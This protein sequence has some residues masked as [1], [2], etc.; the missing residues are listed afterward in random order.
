M[1]VQSADA[2]QGRYTDSREPYHKA[3]IEQVTS[4]VDDFAEVKPEETV[5]YHDVH[6]SHDIRRSGRSMTL[7]DLPLEIF[8]AIVEWSLSEPWPSCDLRVFEKAP[9]TDHHE[10]LQYDNISSLF[11]GV[12]KC[13]DVMPKKSIYAAKT[14]LRMSLVCKDFHHIVMS[15]KTVDKV[16]WRKAARSY[17]DLP[18]ELR[19]IQGAKHS[20]SW[21][22]V[23]RAFCNFERP[24][25]SFGH[26]KQCK[27]ALTWAEFC[28][29][30]NCFDMT[31]DR[32]SFLCIQPGPDVFDQVYDRGSQTYTLNLG[33][34]GGNTLVSIDEFG[35]LSASFRVPEHLNKSSRGQFP[36][37]IFEVAHD[38]LTIVKIASVGPDST[39]TQSNLTTTHT[40]NMKDIPGILN[41]PV[42]KVARC[43]SCNGSLL[44]TLF[45]SNYQDP[46]T[47][48]LDPDECSTLHYLI[49]DPT[50]SDAPVDRHK[51]VRYWSAVLKY[52]SFEKPS[53]SDA[54]VDNTER[55]PMEDSTTAKNMSY[56]VCHMQLSES[57]AAVLVRW[58]STQVDKSRVV[59]ANHRQFHILSTSSGTILQVIE[60]PDLVWDFR[61]NDM[62]QKY[63]NVRLNKLKNLYEMRGAEHR[64]TRVHNDQ[65]VFSEVKN[66][67]DGSA[68]GQIISGSHDYC[69]WLWNVDFRNKNEPDHVLDDYY[70]DIED[71]QDITSA[72]PH[73]RRNSPWS[74]KKERAG[75]WVD[76]PN[77]VL[78]FWHNLI[79]SPDSKRFAACR[80]GKLYIWNSNCS[81][82]TD[83]AMFKG[84]DVSV[85]AYTCLSSPDD[86]CVKSQQVLMPEIQE[87]LIDIDSILSRSDDGDLSSLSPISS[88]ASHS[89]T[90]L[91]SMQS[92]SSM[93]LAT[94]MPRKIRTDRYLGQSTNL[95]LNHQFRNWFEWKSRIPEQGLWM[96][97]ESGL[98]VYLNREDILS[99]SGLSDRR[100]KCSEDDFEPVN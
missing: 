21:R 30:K 97:F 43:C 57:F 39:S 79:Q 51:A 31:N 94:T 32:L 42:S 48:L 77:Q 49:S 14:L 18:A 76:T 80:A 17:F 35:D 93:L 85:E 54:E 12:G 86:D 13:T 83:S 69:I 84:D 52:Q 40:W 25:D 22:N 72:E 20:T 88:T 1:S 61:H 41:D 8:L 26:N 50:Q 44:F 4:D 71:R 45:R 92:Q 19:E 74:T 58:K 90:V 53:C 98:V 36:A 55:L 3:Q 100:W 75:W 33:L 63:N 5:S 7:L 47:A 38:R 62:G 23:F 29:H 65:F 89:P 66:M 27:S 11:K 87:V 78:D 9:S 60:L 81:N 24:V 46:T 70:W 28:I 91:G 95:A 34:L 2:A 15:N 56:S 64:S 16:L 68:R 82:T 96:V 59:D 73:A 99:A 37:D 6:S 67:L 10:G